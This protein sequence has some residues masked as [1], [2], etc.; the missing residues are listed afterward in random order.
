MLLFVDVFTK[1]KMDIHNQLS[2]AVLINYKQGLS[3]LS[4]FITAAANN[5]VNF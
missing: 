4:D 2:P 3:P 1:D 5:R